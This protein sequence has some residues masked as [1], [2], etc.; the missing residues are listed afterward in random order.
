[1]VTIVMYLTAVTRV[2][3]VTMVTII[4]VVTIVTEII[5][6]AVLIAV[7]WFQLK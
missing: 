3:E 7:Q 6:G 4:K 2:Q 5:C 1:M